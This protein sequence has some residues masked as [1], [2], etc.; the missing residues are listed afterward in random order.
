M[1]RFKSRSEAEAVL[2]KKILDL[3]GLTAETT[4]FLDCDDRQCFD[5]QKKGHLVRECKK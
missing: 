4:D 5:C 3:S 1:I 2:Q